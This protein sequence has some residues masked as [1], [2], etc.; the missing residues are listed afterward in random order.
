MKTQFLNVSCHFKRYSNQ[1][2]FDKIKNNTIKTFNYKIYIKV[3]YLRIKYNGSQLF[4][5]YIN[6]LVNMHIKI[7][8]GHRIR[9]IYQRS[10]K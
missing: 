6:G 8:K 5:K 2:G 3:T 9:M 1:K 7:H 10:F 4:Q